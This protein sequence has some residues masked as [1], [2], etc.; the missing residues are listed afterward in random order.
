MLLSL[1]PDG[2][3]NSGRAIALR[4]FPED[5]VQC[6]VFVFWPYAMVLRKYL[7]R[8]VVNDSG[9]DRFTWWGLRGSCQRTPGARGL[10][11]TAL[12]TRDA[13]V[14]SLAAR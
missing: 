6:G 4:G 8:I 1:Y 5:L 10:N 12:P 7:E 3:T 14:A 2:W 9:R 13:Q 11:F